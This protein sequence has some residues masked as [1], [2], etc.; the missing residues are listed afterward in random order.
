[1]VE[2]KK[3]YRRLI[4]VKI[5][6]DGNKIESAISGLK[7]FSPVRV[8]KTATNYS[9]IHGLR[10]G[11]NGIKK[12]AKATN[13]LEKLIQEEANVFTKVD[14]QKQNDDSNLAQGFK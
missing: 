12:L 13:T 4:M 10:S 6:S 3:H 8:N 5:S 1:M 11:D 9:N 14:S 2:F 7:H